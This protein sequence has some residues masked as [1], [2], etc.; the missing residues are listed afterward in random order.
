MAR[1]SA[2]HPRLRTFCPGDPETYTALGGFS[3]TQ[4]AHQWR[5]EESFEAGGFRPMR[6]DRWRLRRALDGVRARHNWASLDA[7][8]RPIG[9]FPH[10]HCARRRCPDAFRLDSQ[11]PQRSN[12]HTVQARILHNGNQVWPATGWADILPD[13][14]TPVSFHVEID[15]VTREIRCYL[16]SNA[17]ATTQPTPSSGTPRWL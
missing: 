4:G 14:S 16:S 17:R 11:G 8:W 10:L 6:W 13:F 3:P 7:A 12:G 5:Y 15:A 9:C 1:G 2:A